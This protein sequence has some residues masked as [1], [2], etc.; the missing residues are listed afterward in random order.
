MPAQELSGTAALV[1]G[2]SRG[3][4]RGI[5]AALSG[6]GAEVVGVA[7]DRGP[8]EE[9]RTQ[10]GS[11]FT[12]VVADAADPVVAGQLLDTFRPRTLVLNA[13]ASPLSR[14]LHQHTWQTFS[15]NWDVDVQQVFHWAREAVLRPLEPGSVVIAFSSGAAVNGSPLSGGYAGAKATIRFLPPYA[16]P[17]AQPARPAGPF[18]SGP[19]P[20]TPPTR[21][22]A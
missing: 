16:A 20:V 11:T 21:P 1:T 12:P 5:A 2:A 3:F 18:L 8:L 10:L 4:G 13:G 22:A 19:P 14:P 15:R 17:E 6:A 9:V 7:C